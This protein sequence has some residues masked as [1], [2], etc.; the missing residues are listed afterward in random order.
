MCRNKSLFWEAVLFVGFCLMHGYDCLAQKQSTGTVPSG[1]CPE[2]ADACFQDAVSGNHGL[3]F[4]RLPG[5]FSDDDFFGG[6]FDPFARMHEMRRRMYDVFRK[7]GGGFYG[8]IGDG[9]FSGAEDDFKTDVSTTDKNI[10][11]SIEIAGMDK[12]SANIK[13]DKSG[14]RI[15]CDVRTIKEEQSEGRSIRSESSKSYLKIIP[16]PFDAIPETAKTDLD[17]NRVVVT[18]DRKSAS[19]K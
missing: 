15:S 8:N 7:S 3:S 2:N 18:F 4:P 13:I 17:K 11:V 14:I 1:E 5:W 12:N 10:I 6:A 16:I 19:A 9:W